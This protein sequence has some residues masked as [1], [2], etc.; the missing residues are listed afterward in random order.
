MKQIEPEYIYPTYTRPIPATWWLRNRKYFLFMMRELSS[1]FIAV[2]LL[3]YLYALSLL[4]K[5]Q[6]AY[7]QFQ[8]SLRSG[9]FTLFFVVAFIFAVY[10]SWT[11]WSIMGKVQVVRLGDQKVPEKVITAV[12]LAGWAVASA[13]VLFVFTR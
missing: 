11:W 13:V 3:V 1:L 8:E 10:H 5:G 4:S 7:G 9:G 12:A 6:A 2:F